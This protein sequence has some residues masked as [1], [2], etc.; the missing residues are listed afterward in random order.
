MPAVFL[1]LKKKFT[2]LCWVFTAACRLSLVLVAATLLSVCEL[3][4]AGAFIAAEHEFQRHVGFSQLVVL[5][6]QLF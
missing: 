4:T 6:A 1:L 2:W 5:Q 3:L